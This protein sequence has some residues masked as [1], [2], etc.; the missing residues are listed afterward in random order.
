[1]EIKDFIDNYLKWLKSELKVQKMG[2]FYEITTPFLDP[3]NDSIQIYVKFVGKRVFFSD[4]GYTLHRLESMGITFTGKRKKQLSDIIMQYGVKQNGFELTAECAERDAPQRKHMFIQAILRINDLYVTSR[5]HVQSLFIDD[6]NE[7]FDKNEIYCAPNI[8]LSGRS[9]FTHSYD[10]L[11]QRSKDKPERLVKA[12]NIAN[13]TNMGSILFS[14]EDTKSVRPYESKLIVIINDRNK[15]QNGVLDG[16]SN[17]DVTTILWNHKD[18][19]EN[20]NILSA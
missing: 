16:F 18:E 15:V 10:F 6:I 11:I 13:Q 19:Q 7:F 9:G 20:L 14:W 3:D 1:M 12:L 2:E 17:Y 4:D 5:N 8:Q